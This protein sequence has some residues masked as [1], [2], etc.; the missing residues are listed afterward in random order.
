MAAGPAP[1]K[2]PPGLRRLRAR[3]GR[4]AAPRKEPPPSGSAGQAAVGHSCSPPAGQGR[5][6]PAME[7]YDIIANQPVVIDNV[8]LGSRGE[9]ARGSA[10]GDP[11]QTPLVPL[12]HCP[13][14][15]PNGRLHLAL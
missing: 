10:R 1:Q 6:G 8:R 13:P 12:A 4:G 11:R 15:T 5:P 7:S 2:T 9:G 3:G 14:A